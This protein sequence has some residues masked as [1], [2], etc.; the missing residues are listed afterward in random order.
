MIAGVIL[1]GGLARRMGGADKP[2][3]PLGGRP[4]LAHVL[5]R[6]APQVDRLALNA[7][8][9]AGRFAAFGLPVL[10]DRL[11]PGVADHPGPLAGILAGLDWAAESGAGS[12]V[13]VAGDTPLPPR[14]LVAALEAAACASGR[15]LVVAFSTR[16]DAGGLQRHPVFAR[17][18]VTLREPLRRAMA[19]G[20][21]RVMDFAEAEGHA[22]AVFTNCDGFRGANTPEELA[23]LER[24]LAG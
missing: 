6:L 20:L 22:R 9:P 10:P 5:D 23:A 3:L 17:W 7:N 14:V 12:L 8:G 4:I 13:T 11:P 2:L 15:P 21:R 19:G 1:A 16:G 24:A 18:P